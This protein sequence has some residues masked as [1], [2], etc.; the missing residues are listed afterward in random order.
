MLWWTHL[1]Y[2]I[3]KFLPSLVASNWW[4]LLITASTSRRR[5]VPM[6]WSSASTQDNEVADKCIECDNPFKGFV[7]V[8]RNKQI[9]MQT[10]IK[11]SFL[12]KPILDII[13][14]K[15]HSLYWKQMLVA[16][17]IHRIQVLLNFKSHIC[18]ITKDNRILVCV[19]II[20]DV[21]QHISNVWQFSQTFNQ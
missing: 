16:D 2:F 10:K 11:C 7:H 5:S 15:Y 21:F 8:N 19:I 1:V 17:R 14:N 12:I 6:A 13:S 3:Q 18:L 9:I 20:F 4:R